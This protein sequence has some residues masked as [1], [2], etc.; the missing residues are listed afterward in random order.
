MENKQVA[1]YLITNQEKAA[2]KGRVSP[3]KGKKCSLETRA[4]ISATQKGK[5]KTAEHNRKNSDGVRRARANKY[6]S[7]WYPQNEVRDVG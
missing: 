2:A 5:P 4:K 3:N 7:N 1:I 6:W